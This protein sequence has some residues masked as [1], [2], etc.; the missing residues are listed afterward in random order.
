MRSDSKKEIVKYEGESGSIEGLPRAGYRGNSQKS[1]DKKYI[2]LIVLALILLIIGIALIVLANKKSE[3]VC[4]KNTEKYDICGYS[5]EAKRVKLGEFISKMKRDYHDIFREEIAWDPAA[6]EK[7][8]KEKFKA[9]D[10]SP[11][12]IKMITERAKKLL[13]EANDLNPDLSKLK[14][15]EHKAYLQTKHFLENTFA[16]SYLNY[17]AGLW[18]MGP[19]GFCSEPICHIAYGIYNSIGTIKPQNKADVDRIMSHFKDYNASIYNYI[20]VLKMGIQKG[21]VRTMVECTAGIDAMKSK[22]PNITK[23]GAKGISGEWYASSFFEWSFYEN[24]STEVDEEIKK[25]HGKN[26]SVYI[27]SSIELYIGQAVERLLKYLEFEHYLYCRPNNDSSGGGLS[28]LPIDVIYYNGSV[29]SGSKTDPFLPNC[30][31][32]GCRLDGKKAYAAILGYF[33][34]KNIHPNDVHKLGW[35]NLGKLYPQVIEI[36]KNVTNLANETAAVDAFKLILTNLSI[37]YFHDTPLPENE[38]KGEAFTKCTDE[39]SAKKYCPTRWKAMMKWFSFAQMAMSIHDPNTVDFFYFTGVRHSTPNCPVKLRPDFIPSSGAQSYDNSDINCTKPCHYNIPFFLEHLGPKFSEYSVN[40][41]EA[42]PGHHTQVQGLTEHFRDKCGG[43]EAWLD[44]KT[45]YTAF[46]EGWALYAENPLIAQGTKI[47]DDNPMQKFGMLKWQIWR[48]LRLIVDTGLHYKNMSRQKALE[49]FEKYAWDNTDLSKKEVTRYQSNYGQATAYMIG[50]LDI[51]S[52][53]NN[54]E[55]KLGDNF[56]MKEFH[57][58]TLSQGSSPLAYLASY[59]NKYIECKNNPTQQY[60]DIVL[61]PTQAA[62]SQ[63]Q[64]SVKNKEIRWP[65]HRHYI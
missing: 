54:T 34:T 20:A 2:F 38:T 53:R 63:T 51:W 64:S 15:R 40:A 46:T 8:I 59:I 21:M 33:T 11:E 1:V 47:Y 45:Y 58:Q 48:A 14:P 6:T 57:L 22:H 60:C 50:Q 28:A 3:K 44:D 9:H 17:T 19:S 31:G 16:F 4:A 18:L 55:K 37:S 23:N 41:H 39:E 61:N 7:D 13:Q 36:A 24:I 26:A 65:T 10:P 29:I 43:P 25:E 27:Q 35:E 30:T 52:L 56:S 5:N 42:R 62:Q 12:N 49:L 32:L